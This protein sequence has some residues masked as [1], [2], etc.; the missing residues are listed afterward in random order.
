[1][2]FLEQL[3]Q[4]PSES[5]DH[6]FREGKEASY[7]AGSWLPGAAEGFAGIRLIQEG[8][9]HV[10]ASV[11]GETLPVSCYD[12]GE[13]LGIR[14]FLRPENQPALRWQAAEDCVV[15]ELNADETRHLLSNAPAAGPIREIFELSAHLRN[16]DILMAIHPLFQT[17]PEKARHK[18]FR[19]ANPI[20]LTPGQMLIQKDQGNE[21]LYFIYN[22]GVDI[23][24]DNQVVAHRS[25]GEIIGEVST[26][27]FA[28][29]ADVRSTG[30]T[31]VLAFD[32]QS[33]LAACEGN[34]AFSAKLSSF[35]FGGF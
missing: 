27:G 13:A 26:L 5:L 10:F 15:Y 19:E 20:A 8:S 30:W 2:S 33:I 9:V 34:Q 22:G 35:G 14:S 25:A 31:D 6:F 28:P 29:T 1:M 23:I 32:R 11:D 4:L 24:N 3:Q 12:S 7:T 16:L 17:L 18:L 21:S